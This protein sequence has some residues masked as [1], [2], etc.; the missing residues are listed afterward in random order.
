MHTIGQAPA[1]NEGFHRIGHR[2]QR[3]FADCG[4]ITG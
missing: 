2:S 1:P 4:D 3:H